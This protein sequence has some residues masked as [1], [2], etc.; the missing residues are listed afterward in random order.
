MYYGKT[1]I[2]PLF[3]EVHPDDVKHVLAPV[4]EIL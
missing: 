2:C 1:G 4:K 3:N